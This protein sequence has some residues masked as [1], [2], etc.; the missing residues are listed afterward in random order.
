MKVFITLIAAIIILASCRKAEIIQPDFYQCNI[1]YNDS[2]LA[3]PNDFIYQKILDDMT[4]SG[5][6]GVT[7]SVYIKNYGMWLG[8]SGKADLHNNIDLKV[9]NITRV[10]SIVKT[11]TAAVV[12]KLYEEGKTGL[13]DKIS[14]YLD[15]DYMN[16]IDNA[17][18]ATIRQLLQHSSG[19][20]NFI[21]NL[22]FETASI[23]DLIR[24]WKAVDLL[25]YAYNKPAYFKPGEDVKYS[26]TNYI[27]LGLLI[28]KIEGKP[29]YQIFD[30]KIINPLDLTNTQFAGKS[31]VPDGI[32]RGYV[33]FYSKLQVIESTYFSG[34]DYYTAD[35][36]LISNPYDL[37]IFI[38]AL[39]NGQILNSNS[40]NEMLNFK[41]P[42]KQY[43]EYFDVH[44]G[45]GIKKM[46][47]DQGDVYCH[48]GNAVGYYANMMFFPDDSTT[49]VYAVN[50]NFGKIEELISTKNAIEKIISVIKK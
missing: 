46:D 16:K 9:C 24:E 42:K 18:I 12:L 25:K 45:L 1:N 39:M 43:P 23:N 50:S 5:V 27:L 28:E 8:T 34:W 20:Y 17:E 35:G 10:G 36:G 47:T 4:N 37:N 31:P 41:T 7:M 6:V 48:D 11:F 21:D 29:L 13:D 44:F 33:D 32:I 14:D 2:S 3:N 38:R 40:L 19:I 22:Q 15:G 30:E 49:I 26:N